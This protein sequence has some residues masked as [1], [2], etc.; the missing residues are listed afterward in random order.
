MLCCSCLVCR[1]HALLRYVT[2]LCVCA[3]LRAG[4]L[5]VSSTYD[6]AVSLP[7]PGAMRMPRSAMQYHVHFL[8]ID[9]CVQAVSSSQSANH[10]HGV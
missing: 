5:D 1:A 4:R 3:G 10:L 2:D 7:F 6:Q 8:T 9:V